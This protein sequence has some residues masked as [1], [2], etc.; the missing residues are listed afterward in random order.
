MIW[1]DRIIRSI[2]DSRGHEYGRRRSRSSGIKRVGNV[3]RIVLQQCQS[4]ASRP[5][6]TTVEGRQ[7]SLGCKFMGGT[8][9]ADQTMAPSARTAKRTRR[10]SFQEHQLLATL[11]PPNLPGSQGLLAILLI[12]PLTGSQGLLAMLCLPN[13]HPQTP[14]PHPPPPLRRTQT[15]RG[16]APSAVVMSWRSRSGARVRRLAS[17]ITLYAPRASR[18]RWAT[19]G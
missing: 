5:T 19:W 6:S 4:S 11:C 10:L 8:G 15:S 7:T 3:G 13:F 9:V 17:T 14:T 12:L 1:Y 18:P 16:S 2:I